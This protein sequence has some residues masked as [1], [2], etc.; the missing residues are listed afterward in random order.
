MGGLF[1]ACVEVGTAPRAVLI[2]FIEVTDDGHR[3]L[4]HSGA[5]ISAVRNR[6][7]FLAGSYRVTTWLPF[8][9]ARL[10]PIGLNF[11]VARVSHSQRAYRIHPTPDVVMR[12]ILGG[13]AHA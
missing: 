3:S 1:C 4:S 12:G 2:A 13:F 11:L 5:G 9:S 8:V 7:Q 10:G 6:L